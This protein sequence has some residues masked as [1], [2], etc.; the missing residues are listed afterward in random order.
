M[1]VACDHHIYSR[2][3]ACV[4]IQKVRSSSSVD[5]PNLPRRGSGHGRNTGLLGRRYLVGQVL[6]R[7]A[8]GE[9]RLG[10]SLVDSF[11]LLFTYDKRICCTLMVVYVYCTLVAAAA[12]IHVLDAVLLPPP[13]KLWRC[14]D[15]RRL[16]V[17]VCL[18][19]C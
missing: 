6:G 12:S 11:C 14:C 16:S 19:V 3:S 2:R 8:F 4:H 18:F 17:S 13:S 5:D 7:G 10:N 9:V 15:S 1:P